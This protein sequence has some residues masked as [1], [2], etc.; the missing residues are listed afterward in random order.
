M[1]RL[2][3]LQISDT[4]GR[5]AESVKQSLQGGPNRLNIVGKISMDD[6]SADEAFGAQQ[7]RYLDSI[8]KAPPTR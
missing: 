6:G 1:R 7:T 8:V 4:L 3:R 5:T 2:R